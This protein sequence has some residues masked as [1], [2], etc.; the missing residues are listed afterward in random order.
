MILSPSEDIEIYRASSRLFPSVHSLLAVAAGSGW[1]AGADGDG[2][3][4]AVWE[5]TT[6]VA[7]TRPATIARRNGR[8]GTLVPPCDL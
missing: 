5:E 8:P 2:G 4:P 3:V 6:T 7:T 1:L